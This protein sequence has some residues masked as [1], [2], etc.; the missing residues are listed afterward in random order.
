[1]NEPYQKISQDNGVYDGALIGS[2][3][4]AGGAGAG[5]FGARMHYNGIEKRSEKQMTALS[6]KK[7]ALVKNVHRVHDK[8]QNKIDKARGGWNEQDKIDE[9][10][11]AR[12]K[13]IEKVGARLQGVNDSI[14][15]A[16][17]LD[18]IRSKHA[19]SRTGGGLKKAGIIGA[20][21]VIGLGIGAATDKLSN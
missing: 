14:A 7:D 21:A 9:I 3:I 13:K 2:A 6:Q 18:S 5:M 1:M 8:Y 20:N 12:N 11:G 17:D 16:S 19:Y 15:H 4:A 10:N